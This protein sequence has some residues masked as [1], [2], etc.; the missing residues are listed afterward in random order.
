MPRLSRRIY[1]TAGAAIVV[2]GVSGCSEVA[3]RVAP[4]RHMGKIPPLPSTGDL[5]PAVRVLNRA[6]FGPSPGD[7]AQVTKTGIAAWIERQLDAPLGPETDESEAWQMRLRLRNIDVLHNESYDLLDW[8]GDEVRAQLQQAALLRAVYSPHQLRERMVDFW[9]NH[10]NIYARKKVGGNDSSPELVEVY[11]ARDN[12]NVIRS[13]ALGTFPQMLQQSA[14]SPAMLGYLDN[15]LNKKGVANENYARELMEL[16]TLGVDGG[17]TQK[18][19][20]EL[21]R[22]L[23]GWTVE[24]RFLRNR[25]TFLYD[26]TLHDDGEKVVLGVRFPAG[27]GERD[28]IKALDL[29]ARHPSCAHFISKKLV[30]YFHGM[31]DEMLIRETAEIYRKT[32]G[33]IKP[34][35][36]HLLTSPAL[37]SS[38]PI[39]KRPFDFVV[40]TLRA[41]NAETD[42]KSGVMEHLEKMGQ[43][44]FQWPMPDGY[45]DKTASWTGSLLARWNF[46]LA[47][48]QNNVKGTSIDFGADSSPEGLVQRLLGRRPDDPVLADLF[49]A[50]RNVAPADRVA[51]ILASPIFQWR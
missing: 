36:A 50:V 15:Q 39:M 33:E 11:A 43:S 49:E 40:S 51:L 27:E 28:G 37:I 22:C 7:V 47:L 14:R 48:S 2:A 26:D 19:V 20:Q 5:S 32:G 9:S 12:A 16:H 23:T 1:L 4:A 13:H 6:A 8:Q 31:E 34:M 41:T 25:G 10:F 38:P 35:V 24:D 45:P 21:A 29:L 17:Y 46:A 44:L 3:R 30:R 18:D 42:G